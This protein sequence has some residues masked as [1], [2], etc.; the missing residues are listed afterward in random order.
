MC[1][2]NVSGRKILKIGQNFSIIGNKQLFI[3]TLSPVL[4]TKSCCKGKFFFSKK[5]VM[6]QVFSKK[7]NDYFHRH[8][9]RMDTVTKKVFY[10]KLKLV[11]AELLK[12]NKTEENL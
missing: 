6:A 1:V 12:C 5:Q 7:E 2:Y 3:N 4:T 11:Y 8:V 9:Q 10:D